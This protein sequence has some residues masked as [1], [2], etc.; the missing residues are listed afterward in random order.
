[1]CFT[2]FNLFVDAY[3]YN[4]KFVIMLNPQFGSITL[5]T[6]CRFSPIQSISRYVR[7]CVC[8]S[9]CMPFP[10]IPWGMSKAK[11]VKY[12]ASNHKIHYVA[13]FRTVYILRDFKMTPLCWLKRNCGFL[14]RASIFV[15]QDIISVLANHPTV[16][17]CGVS[18]V[19]VSN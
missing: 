13:H 16:H 8:Q 10:S 19:R 9:D 1:M 17:I 11:T 14:D 5:L 7:V 6:L 2:H 4:D 18:R 12:N 15:C 3:F